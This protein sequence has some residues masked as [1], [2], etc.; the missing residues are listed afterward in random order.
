MP[1][2]SSV[3]VFALLALVAGLQTAALSA[4]V[5]NRDRLLKQGREIVM[6]VQPLDPRDIFRGDY[7]TLGYPITQ[8]TL[9]DAPT[10]E[11]LQRGEAVYVVL[12]KGEK[13]AWTV[14]RAATSFPKDVTG[15]DVVIRGRVQ[16]VYSGPEGKGV[17]VNARYGIETYFVPE[18]TGRKIEDEVR[19]RTVE[20]I[21]AVGADGEA[22]LKGLIIDNVRTDQPPIF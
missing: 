18:G 19:E 6:A 16:S 5:V 22:A 17:T 9:P 1:A 4:I 8:F 10:P 2:R 7:V 13:N 14:S 12:K 21:L 11:G 20:A 15:D 3:V